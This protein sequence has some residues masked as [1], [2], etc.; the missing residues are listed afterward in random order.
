MTCVSPP[1]VKKP[2]RGFAWSC[3]PCSRAQERKLEERHATLI[4]EPGK[5]KNG[6]HVEE[7]EEDASGAVIR[8]PDSEPMQDYDDDLSEPQAETTHADMWPYRYLGIHCRVEDVLQLDDRAIY[9]RA[10]SRLGPRHQAT[11]PSWPGRPIQLVKPVDVK[12]KYLKGTIIKKETKLSRE[13]VAALE[14][15]K[16]EKANRPKWVQD[17]PVGYVARGEDLDESDPKC[18][19][20]RLFVIPEEAASDLTTRAETS[21][22]EERVDDYMAKARAMWKAPG[23]NVP[24][25]NFLDKA[26]RLLDY[27]KFDSTAALKQLETEHSPKALGDPVL[28]K[29]ELKKFEDGVSKF[30]SELRRVRKHVGTRSYGEIVRFYYMWKKTPRGREIWGNFDGRRVNSKKK[31]T[32]ESSWTD[33]ADDEDDSAFDNDKCSTKKRGFECKFCATRT[34]R[35][36]RRA[37]NVAP[38]ATVPADPKVSVK[39][40]S[41]HL[42]LALCERC[43]IMWRRYAMKWED[44]EE[45]ARTFIQQGSRAVKRRVDEDLLREVVYASEAAGVASNATIA[46]AAAVIGVPVSVQ[47]VQDSGRKKSKPSSDKEQ[48]PVPQATEVQTKKKAPP[49]PPPRAVTPPIVPQQPRMRD[50]PCGVCKERAEPTDPNIITCRDC[51]MA[52]HRRCYAVPDTASAAK[53]LCDTCLNDK[54]WQLSFVSFLRTVLC[55]GLTATA[56]QMHL[57]P[58]C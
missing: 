26:L 17:A 58:D 23:T 56:I 14:A 10:T 47:T 35:R 46:S 21:S 24:S 44:P 5:Q 48:T 3:G 37:P 34:S 31:T 29:E 49:P 8:M 22:M 33:L 51:R 38:G 54:N 27:H 4:V 32:S 50:L 52:V 15:E 20:K 40:K 1:L 39:D 57:V 19:A 45:I 30:G 6:E 7:E 28:S 25:T 16:V 2:S 42:I 13:T 43:A 18:T 36:W 9:P 12:R 53:W 55:I 11:V 41:N